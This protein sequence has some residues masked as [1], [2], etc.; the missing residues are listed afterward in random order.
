MTLEA[1]IAKSMLY[2]HRCKN[3]V[4]L[5]KKE[6]LTEKQENFLFKILFCS[7]PIFFCNLATAK[8]ITY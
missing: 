3:Q 8:I 1:V 2:L 5:F 6:F 4:E 7:K